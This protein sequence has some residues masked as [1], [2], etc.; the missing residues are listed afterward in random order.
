MR[1]KENSKTLR[2]AKTVRDREAKKQGKPKRQVV[3]YAERRFPKEK[4]TPVPA[5]EAVPEV[6]EK[7]LADARKNL[8]SAATVTV[9]PGPAKKLIAGTNRD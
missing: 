3:S 8:T 2:L 5:V 6:A 1:K 4:L 7:P 9:I